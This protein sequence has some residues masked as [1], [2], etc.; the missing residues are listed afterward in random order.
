MFVKFSSAL[1][2]L[3]LS[4]VALSMAM[5]GA[6]GSSSDN[7]VVLSS[8][9]ASKIYV[10]QNGSV[11]VSGLVIDAVKRTLVSGATVSIRIDGHIYTV[12]SAPATHASPGSFSFLLAKADSDFLISVSMSDGSYAPN[13]YAETTTDIGNTGDIGV[14]TLDIGSVELYKPVSTSVTVKN[15]SDG[16]PVT[17]LTLYLDPQ[18]V[19]QA[20]AGD[21]SVEVTIEDVVATEGTT[22]DPTT[23]E[24]TP[25][26]IY[27]FSMPD[28]GKAY[29]IKVKE[30]MDTDS[31]E[32]KG[33]NATITN[34]ILTTL[35]AGADRSFYLTTTGTQDYTIFV[36]LVDENGDAYD[37]GESIVLYKTTDTVP[38]VTG[39]TEPIYA[40][41]VASTTNEYMFMT[42]AATLDFT[43]LNMDT[44]GNG[45]PDTGAVQ[46]TVL[47]VNEINDN[48]TPGDTSD[49]F[50][51]RNILGDGA[52]NA[53]REATVTVAIT[54]ISP[55]QDISAELI[56]GVVH[57]QVGR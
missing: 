42:T 22:T 3:L 31:V 29:T 12:T 49:D 44:D 9:D 35:T 36:H 34:N 17:G 37:A 7:D 55:S 30:L 48:G 13:Y 26:G 51:V 20:N 40:E 2:L 52:F 28:D 6:C 32:Y 4:V 54:A 43:I 56:R 53:D 41:R 21:S 57:F 15:I 1:R 45:F 14:L 33:Y 5:L 50:P 11:T 39:V 27:T 47:N 18:A 38:I 16:S 46:L 24:V 19:A 23:S 8:S 25:T 10:S